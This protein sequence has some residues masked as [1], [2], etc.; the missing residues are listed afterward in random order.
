MQT[1]QGSYMHICM[2]EAHAQGGFT[3]LATLTRQR[4]TINV[5]DKDR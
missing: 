3:A 5:L 1:H 4:N 2:I